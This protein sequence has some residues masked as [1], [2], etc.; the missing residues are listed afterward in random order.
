MKKNKN[1]RELIK[2]YRD[3]YMM[4]ERSGNNWTK[5]EIEKLSGFFYEGVGISAIALELQRTEVAVIQQL[6]YQDLIKNYGVRR[7][8][9]KHKG[10]CL[11]SKCELQESCSQNRSCQKEG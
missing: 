9:R 5:D 10:T 3:G 8:R 7:R 11:C 4:P 2:A 6:M 1:H